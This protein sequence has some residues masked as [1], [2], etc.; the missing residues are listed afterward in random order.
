[1]EIDRWPTTGPWQVRTVHN[2]Y[3]ALSK[4]EVLSRNYDRERRRIAGVGH[5]EIMIE[6]THHNTTP[7][8][9]SVTEIEAVMEMYY[10]RGWDIRNDARIKQIIY[11]KNHG[12]SAGASLPHPHNQ[13]IGLPVVP[14]HTRQRTEEAR[15]FFDDTG[16]CVFCVMMAAEQEREACLVSLSEHFLAFVLYAAPSPFYLWIVPRRHSVSYL[17]TNPEERADLA[18][19]LKDVLIR[20]FV[21]LRDPAY[22]LIIHSAPVQEMGNDYLHWYVAVIPRLSYT[23]GFELG[24][25]MY[26]NPTLPEECAA[27][28]RE[29]HT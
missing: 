13:I 6:H 15:R 10:S 22:N 25:G 9:M 19:I 26:I 14:T 24:S 21:G 29:V 1:L 2:R 8:L 5:H 23:A 17:Y 7:A 28:L 11:F 16:E 4:T 3:P 27:F 20:L 12:P 18:K